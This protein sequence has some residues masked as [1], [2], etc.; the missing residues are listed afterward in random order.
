MVLL[1]SRKV[2]GPDSHL[3]EPLYAFANLC[4]LMR[5]AQAQARRAQNSTPASLIALGISRESSNRCHDTL[6][7]ARQSARGPSRGSPQPL[8][9]A[10]EPA[11]AT[12]QA[13]RASRRL[14]KPPALQPAE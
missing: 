10:Y 3:S 5:Q 6:P 2:M 8:R 7:L 14:V 13:S 4:Y 11:T 9:T 1:Y 12:L